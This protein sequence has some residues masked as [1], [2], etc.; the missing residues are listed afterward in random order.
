LGDLVDSLAVSGKAFLDMGTG[1]GILGLR[2]AR[3]GARV[4]ALDINP[5][6]VRC[7]AGNARKNG[8]AMEVLSSDLFDAVPDRRF[9]IVV[10]NVP[11]LAGEP[12]DMAGKAFLGGRDLAV[13]VRFSMRLADHLRPGGVFFGV[14]SADAGRRVIAIFEQSGFHV[15]RVGV[16]RWG[17][18]ERMLTFSCRPDQGER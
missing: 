17:L 12:G 11:F 5:A 6:A 3:R 15:E 8:I 18:G 14:V 7:A 10:W 2:A 1:S 9:D 13:V 4:T 16:R